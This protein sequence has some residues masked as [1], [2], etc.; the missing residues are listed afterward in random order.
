MVQVLMAS[1]A[2]RARMVIPQVVF[3]WRLDFT[4]YSREQ[5]S[6]SVLLEL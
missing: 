3:H 1:K 2:S 6:P 4:Q 5:F